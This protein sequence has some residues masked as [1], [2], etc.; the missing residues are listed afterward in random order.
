MSKKYF[1][2]KSIKLEKIKVKF[3]L[4]VLDMVIAFI[5]KDSV[6]RTHKTLHNIQ[7]LFLGLDMSLYADNPELTDRIWIINKTIEKRFTDKIESRDDFLRELLK[8]EEDC[9][10][11]AKK[12]IDGIPDLKITHEESKVLIKKL[13]DALYFGYT[14]YVKDSLKE[15]LDSIDDEDIKTFKSVEATLYD[16]S[17]AIINM[18][19]SARMDNADNMFSLADD[20]FDTIIDDS[21][22]SLK[23]RNK[24]FVTGLKKL[25]Q[26]LAPAYFSKKLYL[27]LAFPGKGKSQIL[28][29]SALAI[30]KYNNI[31]PK[32]PDKR[33]A[34]LLL[35]LENSIAETVER[36][37]NMTTDSDDIRNYSAK[38]IKKRLKKIGGLT[39]TDECPVDLII[40][41]YK[42]REL[43]TDDIY[44]IID[45]LADQ[46]IEV[47]TLIV[48]YIKRLRPAERAMTE[49]EELKNISNE[50]KEIA[51]FYDIP[52]ITAQQL[53]RTG[54]SVVDAAIQNNKEDVTRLVGSDS[55]AGAWELL[56]NSDW[57][58]II[59]PEVKR[60][61][62][63]LF[64]T[65]K[66]LKRRYRSRDDDDRMT[67]FNQP[68]EEDNDIR[69]VEDIELPKSVAL[70]SLATQ[71]TGVEDKRG[72]TNV[73]ERPSMVEKEKGKKKS[74][75][76]DEFQP[77]DET[78]AI[79]Y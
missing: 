63:Q 33:P 59:N 14:A 6:L 16:I 68:Y 27:Y 78:K 39:L 79:N 15:V 48:D 20:I 62:G 55:I 38:Q 29:Y 74:Q 28:L 61:T 19:R 44:G 42:N 22:A 23:D 67:Y 70:E 54:M 40:Q 77:F 45:D 41:E 7:K 49:K 56:E 37:Y 58:C 32:D 9:T 10:E 73:I 76:P 43:S 4:S 65:F 46:G 47:V 75:S 2:S 35:N 71:F 51:K 12:I 13:E 36:M 21:M 31:K 66:L 24:A 30:R 26:F 50:L 5:Y 25:N 34:I 57:V 72:K 64:L 17:T 8:D 11:N 52:C 3:S 1:D 60:D 69:L 53:N 18:R